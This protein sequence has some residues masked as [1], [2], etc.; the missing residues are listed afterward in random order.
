MD[1]GLFSFQ[2]SEVPLEWQQETELKEAYESRRF[3]KKLRQTHERFPN[4]WTSKTHEDSNLQ[5]VPG[6]DN[7]TRGCL[8]SQERATCGLK[9][10]DCNLRSPRQN[11]DKTDASFGNLSP[12]FKYPPFSN[13]SPEALNTPTFPLPGKSPSISGARSPLAMMLLSPFGRKPSE[14]LSMYL[15]DHL[16][17]VVTLE[18]LERSIGSPVFRF[19]NVEDMQHNEPKCNSAENNVCDTT[20]GSQEQS[21]GNSADLNENVKLKQDQHL[22]KKQDGAL[23]ARN[24]LERKRRNEMNSKYDKLKQCIPEIE[25]RTKVSKISILKSA[26][27]YIRDLEKQAELLTKQQ[28]LEKSRNE[29]LLKK[30]ITINSIHARIPSRK[31]RNMRLGCPSSY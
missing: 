18:L 12:E 17:P 14:D 19:P 22:K 25:K 26:K 11:G 30:L 29:E 5:V 24:K 4:W 3:Q 20:T 27:E 23:N 6:N 13:A 7:T 21:Q 28:E 9:C 2:M 16:T 15:P 10:S 31:R 8:V 1:S